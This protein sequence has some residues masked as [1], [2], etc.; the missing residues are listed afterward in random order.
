MHA[1]RQAFA[2]GFEN[3]LMRGLRSRKYLISAL[4]TAYPR[5]PRPLA[6]CKVQVPL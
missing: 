3:I 2:M 5:F 1:P 6:F 4:T